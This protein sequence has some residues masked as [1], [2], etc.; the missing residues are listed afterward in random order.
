M[1]KNIHYDNEEWD[2]A[3]EREKNRKLARKL[4]GIGIVMG[5][6]GI[7]VGIIKIIWF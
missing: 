3:K 6:V 1:N 4:A 5:S 7:I 2:F